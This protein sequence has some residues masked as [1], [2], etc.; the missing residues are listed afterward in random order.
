MKNNK[1]SI[2]FT[3]DLSFSGYFSKAYKQE[4]VYAKEVTDFLNQNDVNVINQE[5]PIT[6]CK[7]TKKRRLAHRSDPEVIGYI[8]EQIHNPIFSLANNHMMDY[9]RIGMMDTVENMKETNSEFIGA[10][11]NIDEASKYVI[12]GQD[13]KVGIFSVQYKDYRVAG[14]RMSGPFY[15]G[16]LD[17]IKQRIDELKSKVDWV[18]VVYHGGDEFLFAPMPYTRKL[19]ISYLNMGADVVV[20]HHPHVVQGYETIGKKKIFYSLGNFMFDTDYQRVQEG[21]TEGMMLRLV[22]G[23]DAYEFESMPIHINR[24][25][26]TVEKGEE[27]PHFFDYES[28]NYTKLWCVEA[29]RKDQTLERARIL[30]EESLEEMAKTS[31]NE[32]VRYE[33]LRMEH[34]MRIAKDEEKE[35]NVFDE[36]DVDDNQKQAELDGGESLSFYRK[37]RRFFKKTSRK[38]KS[39]IGG[40]KKRTYRRGKILY[41]LLYKRV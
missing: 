17:V 1:T 26:H 2:G 7:V 35:G 29:Y 11:V 21:T 3:G 34:E 36:G 28:K 16:K 27:N 14:K 6:Q 31:E 24:E 37:S 41:T 38:T 32:K 9:N 4:Q 25:Q 15:E 19:L 33:Q 12:V 30:R 13:V 39:L 20:A 8:K 5:S 23:K 18:V 22:F 10:G 40:K